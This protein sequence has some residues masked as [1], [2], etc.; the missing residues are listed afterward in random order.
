MGTRGLPWCPVVET[1]CSQR[2]GPGSIPGQ[3]TRSHIPQPRPACPK[4]KWGRGLWVYPKR[5]RHK[6]RTLLRHFVP[7]FSGH[8]FEVWA[9]RTVCALGG[10]ACG[11]G[12]NICVEGPSSPF[13]WPSLLPAHPPHQLGAWS[14]GVS[15]GTTC[16]GGGSIGRDR[17]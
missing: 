3:G 7:W 14:L 2:R 8:S 9:I 16:W 6:T 12:V 17:A 11:C 10:E 13:C 4:K 5:A 1:L 15:L